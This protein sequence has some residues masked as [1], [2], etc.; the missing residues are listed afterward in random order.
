MIETT[1]SSEGYAVRRVCQP[2]AFDISVKPIITKSDAVQ[3][4]QDIVGEG[5]DF[6][7][8]DAATEIWEG[9]F[10]ERMETRR[11]ELWS[12]GDPWALINAD[13]SLS[14]LWL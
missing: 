14:R 10:G 12:L 11:K 3:W 13:T 6:H 8:D 1:T 9:P 7:L 2:F 5:F 4:L